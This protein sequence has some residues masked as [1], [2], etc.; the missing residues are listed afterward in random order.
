MIGA[1][2]HSV[3]DAL[4]ARRL[5]CTYILAGH[6]YATDCKKGLPGRGLSFLK[7]VCDAV[8]IPVYAIGGINENNIQ[9]TRRAGAKGVCLMS[10]LMCCGNV[11]ELLAA[12]KEKKGEDK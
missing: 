8:S 1:S 2:C 12:M 9:Q 3:E 7:Q 10:S 5:G 11:Q 6:I 4:E